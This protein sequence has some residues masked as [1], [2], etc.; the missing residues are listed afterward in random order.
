MEPIA[1]AAQR[2]RMGQ[3]DDASQSAELQDVLQQESDLVAGH[4][5]LRYTGLISIS[6]PSADELEAAVAGLEQ[7]AIQAGL[8]TRLLVTQQAQGFAAAALPLARAL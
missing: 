8:E 7:A 5:I 2:A 1:D 3:I 4:G 6:A